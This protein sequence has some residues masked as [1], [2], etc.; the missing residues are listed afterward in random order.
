MVDVATNGIVSA[1]R[2]QYL[3]VQRPRYAAFDKG[4]GTGVLITAMEKLVSTLPMLTTNT[5]SS[6]LAQLQGSNHSD[7]CGMKN[8]SGPAIMLRT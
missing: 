2:Q 1:L 7:A 6:M 3:A 4:C 8:V 5:P